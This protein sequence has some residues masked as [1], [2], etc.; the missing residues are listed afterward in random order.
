MLSGKTRSAVLEHLPSGRQ[1]LVAVGV[2]ITPTLSVIQVDADRVVL[3]AEDG[4]TTSLRLSHGGQAPARIPP[5][6][7][8]R[9]R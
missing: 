5:R 2:A 3:G 6:Q 8:W 7:P 9:R 4:A 1:E